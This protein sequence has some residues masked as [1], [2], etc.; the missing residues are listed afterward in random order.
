MAGILARLWRGYWRGGRELPRGGGDV[1]RSGS[2]GGGDVPHSG[3]PD[4]LVAEQA[5]EA[6]VASLTAMTATERPA[7]ND[8]TA[9]ALAVAFCRVLYRYPVLIGRGISSAWV[10]G[11]YPLLCRAWGVSRPPPYKD[12][13]KSL[14][15]LLPR[16]RQDRRRRGGN[17][18]TTTRYGLRHP[19]LAAA[20]AAGTRTARAGRMPPAGGSWP[21][22]WPRTIAHGS[23]R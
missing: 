22:N 6:V 10:R 8:M 13:A 17:R 5:L 9:E 7:G 19:T 15:R 2:W 1:P 14:A 21:Q 11:H 16:S 18:T 23:V 4:I 20:L 3:T 12:F